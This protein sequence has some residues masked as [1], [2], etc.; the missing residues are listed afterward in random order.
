MGVKQSHAGL[1]A[2]YSRWLFLLSLPSA[3]L[4]SSA[5]GFPSSYAN[6]IGYW[7][8]VVGLWRCQFCSTSHA[9]EA[10]GLNG[11]VNFFVCNEFI[12]S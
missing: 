9:Y 4:F 11:A 12:S 7:G 1:V 3:S 2:L 5:W 10:D 8:N 6:T